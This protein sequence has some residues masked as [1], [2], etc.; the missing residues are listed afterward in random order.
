MK[1][2][3]FIA[4][5][6]MVRAIGPVTRLELEQLRGQREAAAPSLDLTPG[7]ALERVIHKFEQERRAV[8]ES[9]IANRLERM[10]GRASN[11][12]GLA[13]FRGRAKS[14]FDRER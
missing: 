11:D 8:R 1:A 13:R 5:E 7:G 4:H 3:K 2:P 14:S 9:Y 12:F 10:E 6:E